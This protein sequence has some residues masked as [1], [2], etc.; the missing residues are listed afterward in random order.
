MSIVHM[1]RVTARE[2]RRNWFRLLDE[3]VQW[4]VV[5]IERRGRWIIL[6]RESESGEEAGLPDYDNLRQVPDM[7]EAHRWGGVLV[8]GRGNRGARGMNVLLGTHFLL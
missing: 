2:A 5:C 1:K 3:V 6:R 8:R 4:A 7:D